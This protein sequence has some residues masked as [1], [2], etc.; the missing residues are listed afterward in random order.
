MKAVVKTKKERG[1]EYLDVPVPEVGP[2]D[3]LIKVAA[4]AICGTDIHM[5]QWNKWAKETVEKAYGPLPR[6]LG[7]E[8]SG[9][10]VEIGSE[11][12]KVKVGD[13]VAA[14]THIPCGECFLCR[15]G[16]EYNC[17]NL[18]RFKD[19]VFGEYAVIP[20]YSAELVPTNISPGAAALF[21]P[22]GVAVHA[23]SKV[24]M[25]GDTV[26]IIGAGPVGLFCTL[27][28]KEMG[29]SR[30][31]VSDVSDYRLDLAEKAGA[32]YIFNPTQ[33]KIVDEV[34][35]LSNMNGAGIV[36][37][38]SGNVMA[39]KQGFEALRK[40]GSMVMVGLPSEPLK[41]DAGSDIVWKGAKVYGSYGRDNFTS[42]EI[43]KNLLGNNRIDLEPFITHRF[44]FKDFKEALELCESGNTGKVLL[45]PE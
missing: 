28:A 33:V 8:V 42:W 11:V 25:V 39:T 9:E 26:F 16:N 23:T 31:I 7:H 27:L 29:A 30:I 36:I 13:L 35:K 15:T 34:Y 10:V 44:G 2:K 43:A 4:G 3:V 45:L 21:E 18:T 37:E 6:I 40:C 24:R 38:T 17:Q 14:E 20:E 32:D 1:A 22:F 12:S 19:G 41:L 5:Y